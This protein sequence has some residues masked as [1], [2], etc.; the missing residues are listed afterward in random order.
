MTLV[1]AHCQ[2]GDAANFDVHIFDRYSNE[3]VCEGLPELQRRLNLHFYVPAQ[4]RCCSLLQLYILALPDP[5]RS[6]D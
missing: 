5:L 2:A 6:I 3:L 1:V 4:V